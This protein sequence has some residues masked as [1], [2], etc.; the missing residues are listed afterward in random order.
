MTSDPEF[1]KI[2]WFHRRKAGLSRVELATLAG[3]GKTVIFDIEHEK[4]TVKA[5]TL[6]KVLDTL[7]IQVVVESP[8]MQEFEK[9]LDEK[10]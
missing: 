1:G 5:S 10:R 6:K 2:I 9:Q 3:V 8:L 7:N 4:Q